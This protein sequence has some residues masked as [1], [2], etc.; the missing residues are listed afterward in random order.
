MWCMA[1]PL[2]QVLVE[3]ISPEELAKSYTAPKAPQPD[4]AVAG[5]HLPHSKARESHLHN[6]T[7]AVLC[8]KCPEAPT[9]P[10]PPQCP[11]P[12][13]CPPS[14]ATNTNKEER[15][16][17][18]VALVEQ[19]I[20]GQEKAFILLGFM[21]GITVGILCGNYCRTAVDRDT[22][23]SSSR[24]FEER[25]PDRRAGSRFNTPSSSFRTP[26]SAS[27]IRPIKPRGSGG[28][29]SGSNLGT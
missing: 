14:H 6:K 4:I 18:T 25:T 26:S 10:P 20:M 16:L 21:I 13:P 17:D 27:P 15:R 2:N 19:P 12:P 23:T 24:T 1:L 29:Y 9:C 7:A 28:L 8:P 22:R 5:V 11:P 3:E